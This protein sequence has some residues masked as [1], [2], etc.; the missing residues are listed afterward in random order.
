MTTK[1][2]ME[3]RE[4]RISDIQQIQVVRNSVKENILSNPERVTDAHVK[5]YI[6]NRGKGWVCESEGKIIGFAIADLVDDNVWA[7]FLLPEYE[8]RGFGRLLHDT[9]LDWYFQQH[10]ESIWLSTSPATRADKFYRI[11][12]W[13]ETGMQP[14]GEIRF[15]MKKADWQNSGK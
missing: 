13:K 3:I 14:N 4:A 11:A 6:T 7:L 1:Q 2:K 9:L 10:K 15:E 5:D 8:G 12:G